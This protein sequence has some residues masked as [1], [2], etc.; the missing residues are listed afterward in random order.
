MEIS[1]FQTFN[2]TAVIARKYDEAIPWLCTLD[3]KLSLNEINIGIA[4]ACPER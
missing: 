1:D 4:R 3:R 2:N